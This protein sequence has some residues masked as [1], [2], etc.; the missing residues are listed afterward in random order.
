[1]RIDTKDH[2]S[3][4]K[5]SYRNYQV[6]TSSGMLVTFSPL[7]ASIQKVAVLSDDGAETLIALA[8]AEDP[9]YEDCICY[10]GATLC[11]NAGRIRDSHIPIEG[12]DYPLVPNEAPNQLHGGP[13]NLSSAIWDTCSVEHTDDSVRIT[14]SASQQDGEDGYP[15][16]RAYRVAYTLD[17]TNWLTV[18]YHALTD[19]T[20]YI[21]MSGHTYWN[22]TGDF[23]QNALSQELTLFSNN[24]GLLD[25]AHLPIN[26]HPVSDTPFDFRKGRSLA[27][28]MQSSRDP[29][30]TQQLE[31]EKG[32]NHPF[33]LNKARPGRTLR[34]IRQIPALKKACILKDPASGRT[35][36]MMT[37]APVLV[38]YS[39]GFLPNGLRLANGQT[40][41]PSCAIALEA[42]DLPD[43]MHMLPA[44]Y[45]L[46]TPGQPFERIIRYHIL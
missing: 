8:F 31:Q 25:K 18:R 15:G 34:S 40:C 32:L 17:D 27:Q 13:H 36:Q 2:I 7:G 29:Q 3:K 19:K 37:D 33:L 24:V 4:Y 12:Q 26:I 1:M 38:V 10:A 16:D 20:T 41:V 35:L 11:P 46:T 45:P 28:G 44:V 9:P 22:L 21:N 5:A 23:T 39:G 43:V 6:T 30:F 42:Q 14:F